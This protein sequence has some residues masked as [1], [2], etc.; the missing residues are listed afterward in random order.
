MEKIITIEIDKKDEMLELHL[1]K[2]GAEFLKNIL[3]KLIER[4]TNCDHHL[5][6]AD[7]GGNEL[8]TEKQNQSESMELIHQL[9]IMY[10]KE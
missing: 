6:S 9:K 5:M 7:W 3:L 8:T 1:N 4:D 2:S 10:W